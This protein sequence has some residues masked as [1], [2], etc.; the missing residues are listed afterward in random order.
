MRQDNQPA[1]ILLTTPTPPSV[2]LL[3]NAQL[4]EVEWHA[5]KGHLTSVGIFHYSHAKKPLLMFHIISSL[6]QTKI[7]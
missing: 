4:R 3:A 7:K 1:Q 2:S 6:A 5:G